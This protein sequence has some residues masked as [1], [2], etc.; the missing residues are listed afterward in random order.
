[1][2]YSYDNP[3]MKEIIH[4]L[5]ADEMR[6]F[7]PSTTYLAHLPPYPTLKFANSPAL[8]EEFARLK[9]TFPSSS[10]VLSVEAARMNA[11][12]MKRYAGLQP[13]DDALEQDVQA[14]KAC[15]GQAKVQREHQHTRLLNLEL[16][17]QVGTCVRPCG[18]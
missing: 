17:E 5:I 12:D 1:M 18:R 8:A 11:L 3:Q 6:S 15:V 16:A 14:W 13:P 7:T 10:S 2:D 9:K 4:G